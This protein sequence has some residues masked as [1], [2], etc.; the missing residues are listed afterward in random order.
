MSSG[1]QPVYYISRR[2]IIKPQDRRIAAVTERI[3][4]GC[5]ENNAARPLFVADSQMMSQEIQRQAKAVRRDAVANAAA[6]MPLHLETAIGQP[7]DG[8]LQRG[9]RDH[10][11]LV[12]VDQQNWW[13]RYCFLLQI[14]S[15]VKSAGKTDDGGQRLG[16][17]RRDMQAH[18]RPLAKADQRG[19]GRRD[20]FLRHCLGDVS[21]Q[22]G[23]R[24]MKPGLHL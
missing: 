1:P 3:V 8:L 15:R 18:H 17:P 21:V 10:F 23:R 6:N 5:G 12:A 24:P 11:I 13:P 2:A 22:D 9:N 16:P 14:I 20:T 19:L 7:I 4:L